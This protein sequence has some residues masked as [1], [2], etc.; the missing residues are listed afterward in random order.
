MC[1]TIEY[2]LKSSA[3]VQIPNS[4]EQSKRR[5][6]VGEL[7]VGVILYSELDCFAHLSHLQFFYSS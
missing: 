2:L 7:V 3:G 1:K 4:L 6:E 5:G